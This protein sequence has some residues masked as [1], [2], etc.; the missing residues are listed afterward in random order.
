[1]IYKIFEY[2]KWYYYFVND[3]IY[4]KLLNL[5]NYLVGSLFQLQLGPQVLLRAGAVLPFRAQLAHDVHDPEVELGLDLVLEPVEHD[6]VLLPLADVLQLQ[7]LRSL[8]L[9]AQF[10]VFSSTLL[11]NMSCCSRLSIFCENLS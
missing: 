6:L 9:V 2:Y 4:T 11:R 5:L 8:P 10:L 7:L 1:L 3:F